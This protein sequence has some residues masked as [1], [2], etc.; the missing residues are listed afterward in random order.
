MLDAALLAHSRP[1]L[2]DLRIADASNHQIPYLLERREDELT[3]DLPPL[4]RDVASTPARSQYRLTL[5]FEN[6]PAARLVLITMEK[7]F[8]RNV[9]VQVPDGWEPLPAGFWG[10]RK[11][12]PFWMCLI[13][14]NSSSCD[15]PSSPACGRVKSWRSSGSMSPRIT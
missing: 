15:S 12:K 1:D 11:S 5:P 2:A 4:V 10:L 3:V 6:L 13:F 7:L 9:S 14:A 8:Q